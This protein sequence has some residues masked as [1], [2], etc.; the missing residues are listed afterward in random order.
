[1]SSQR[2]LC[3][4][5]YLLSIHILNCKCILK[6]ALVL[7]LIST[8]LSFFVCDQIPSQWSAFITY[9]SSASAVSLTSSSLAP[10]LVNGFINANTLLTSLAPHFYC[11]LFGI[12]VALKPIFEEPEKASLPF[13]LWKLQM[14][15]V[16]CHHRHCIGTTSC[17]YSF[18]SD[19]RR[20]RAAQGACRIS[21]L[22][23]LVSSMVS[24]IFG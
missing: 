5:P 8:C 9:I 18:L 3:P 24:F 1:M 17:F 23:R 13:P 10:L 12:L 16:T 20:G 6:N 11:N 2:L 22:Q 15:C 4:C 19:G 7:P 14:I 21:H